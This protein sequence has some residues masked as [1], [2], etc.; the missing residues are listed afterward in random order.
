[1]T[2][3]IK[4][5]AAKARSERSGRTSGIVWSSGIESGVDDFAN[6]LQMG[7]DIRYGKKVMS[8]VTEHRLI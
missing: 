3:L 2:G 7:A 6:V 5:W 8:H 4:I 1:M